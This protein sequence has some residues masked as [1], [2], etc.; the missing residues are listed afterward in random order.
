MSKQQLDEQGEATADAAPATGA[1][2]ADATVPANGAL[3]ASG[4]H[5]DAPV[6]P[7]GGLSIDFSG[8]TSVA[9]PTAP[10]PLPG[11]QIDFGGSDAT[12]VAMPGGP[13]FA[14]H[15]PGRT[16]A[17]VLIVGSGPAGLTAAIYA[18][19]ANLEPIVLAGS[20]PGGQLMLTSD[21]ENYPGFRD[22]IQ[23]PDLMNLFRQQAERFGTQITDVDI[24]RVDL[25]SPPVPDLGTRRRVPRAIRHRRDRGVRQCAGPPKR[26]PPRRPRLSA[27]ATG[28]G[29]FF[30]KRKSGGSGAA[31]PRFKKPPTP[32]NSPKGPWLPAGKNFGE[33]RIWAK[34]RPKP[35]N[36]FSPPP[37]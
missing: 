8:D 13:A 9:A 5:A 2:P 16:E 12:A 20:T 21:V 17:K 31:K 34:P 32:P 29:F 4:A 35:Q 30:P 15:T 26:N 36:R 37:A 11:L 18:A 28:N 10:A 6:S 19:R 14:A 22:G 3:P 24:D 25:S 33:T 7:F 23:G 27:C 1:V